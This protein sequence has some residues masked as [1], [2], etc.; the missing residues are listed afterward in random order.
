MRRTTEVRH[1]PDC[2]VAPGDAHTDHCDVARCLATGRQRLQC[3]LDLSVLEELF[4]APVQKPAEHDCGQELWTGVWPGVAECEEFGWFSYFR[5]PAPG[6]RYGE[7]IRCGVD[8]PRAGA[9]LNRLAIEG[10]WDTV[11][12]RFR[13]PS[14][15][16]ALVHVTPVGRHLLQPGCCPQNADAH[17]PPSPAGEQLAREVEGFLDG[18]VG[19]GS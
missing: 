9:D 7:W 18:S 6:E 2:G 12:H 13:N 11:A 19:G 14:A 10:V 17:Y 15:A 8:N 4:R 1:C 5:E 3:E 16:G